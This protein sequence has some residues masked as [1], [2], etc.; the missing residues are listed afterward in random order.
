MNKSLDY[1]PQTHH[2]DHI[3]FDVE[4]IPI[5]AQ[6]QQGINEIQEIKVE[7]YKALYNKRDKQV[8]SIVT[9]NYTLIT[10]RQALEIGKMVFCKLFPSVKP[11]D[12][13]P[14]KVI[15]TTKLSSCHIDLVHKDINLS[16]WKQD[17]WLPFL[18]ISNS[19]NRT[20]ALS[21]EI[22]F[23]RE[24]CSNG[25]IFDK[26][27]IKVKY[28]H[29]RGL[30]PVDFKVD[31]SRLRKYEVEFTN[32]LN[33]LSRFYVD[34]IYVF[35]LVLKSLNLKFNLDKNNRNLHNE[36][37]RLEKTR[38]IISELTKS[39]YE[40]LKPTAYAVLSIITDFV[41]HQEKYNTIPMFKAHINSYYYKPGQ[42]M[43]DFTES[44]QKTSFNMD[45]YLGDFL[46]YKN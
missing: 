6:Y 27:S 21:F 11:E 9:N 39:Y 8:L 41:S 25:F 46:T 18:R 33:N 19:Y 17:T 34:P 4:Q 37:I 35:P 40:E 7:G 22:G 38:E 31:V 15:S 44:I 30:M 13:I 12:L 14:F 2:L 3:L 26:E 45:D 32:Y 1:K 10:N 24:L 20:I 43:H 36:Q 16:Q 42:W 28:A 5:T 23:V 29:T